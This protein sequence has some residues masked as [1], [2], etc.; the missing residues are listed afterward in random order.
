MTLISEFKACEKIKSMA[1][2]RTGVLAFKWRLVGCTCLELPLMVTS[3]AYFNKDSLG[4][5]GH[6]GGSR[7]SLWGVLDPETEDGK[8]RRMAGKGSASLVQTLSQ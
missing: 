3:G 5:G 4:G 6:R 8:R 7:G 1:H 2:S